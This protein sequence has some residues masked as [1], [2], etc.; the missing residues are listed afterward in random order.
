MLKNT[1]RNYGAIARFLHWSTALL[2][3][4]AYMAVYYRHWFTDKGTP[5]N[6]TALQLH[7]SLGLSIAVLV[8]LR[9]IWTLSNKSPAHEPGSRWAHLAARLGHIALYG[10]LIVMPLTG[11]LGTGV[12]TDWFFLGEVPKF[13]DTTLFKSVVEGQLGLSFEQFEAPIDFIHKKG[14]AWVVWV[15]ILG[16]AG[17]ALYHHFVLKD[18][19]LVKMTRGKG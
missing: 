12:A 15:L 16:H 11:Y 8:V 17:A 14:G 2:F 18:R 5:E 7:L 4:G 9:V 19:T 6:W 10:V 1:E 3:L 13:A